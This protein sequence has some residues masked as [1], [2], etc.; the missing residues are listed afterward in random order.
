MATLKRWNGTDW[1]Y[2]GLPS[3]ALSST[4]AYSQSIS[5]SASLTSE[6][7][8][9]NLTA[10]VTVPAGRRLR[11]TA[12]LQM[13]G[14]V[15]GNRAKVHLK[16]QADGA[17]LQEREVY[18]AQANV[19]N[20]LHIEYVIS[21]TAG[22]HTFFLT[23][24]LAAGTGN[25]WQSAAASEPSF[26][27][28]EDITGVGVP[29]HTHTEFGDSGWIPLSLLNGWVSYDNTYGPP[30]YRKLNGVVYVQGLVKS[31]S[32]GT[33][34]AN[35]PAGF[36]PGNGLPKLLFPG[37]GNTDT[38]ATRIDVDFNGNIIHIGGYNA[39]YTLSGITFPA[40][41]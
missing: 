15:A 24:M 23:G 2:V 28:I 22:T 37:N 30:R 9:P 13:N 12:D 7:A 41:Q 40:D 10:T 34:I 17:Y 38:G 31:G 11:I 5:N 35:L 25:V 19:A 3:G 27:L 1:E 33:V 16:R 36:R 8:I 39:Y 18:M 26:L 32:L 14:S 20:P 4:L 6:A 21:P 29:G